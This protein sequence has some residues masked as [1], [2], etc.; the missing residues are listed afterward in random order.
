MKK[1]LL[2]ILLFLAS[3]TTGYPATQQVLVANTMKPTKQATATPVP[4]ATIDYAA[5][6]EIAQATANKAMFDNLQ[7]TLQFQKDAQEQLQ[8]TA[9]ADKRNHEILSWTATAALTSFPATATQ[10]AV[11]NTQIPAKQTEMA[12][13][14]TSTAEYPSLIIEAEDAKNYAQ[15]AGSKYPA[16]IFLLI[17]GGVCFLA[18]AWWVIT[19]AKKRAQVVDVEDEPEVKS[20]HVNVFT[21]DAHSELHTIPGTPEEFT[22]LSIAITSGLRN[23][24]INRWQR[25]GDVL[26]D[27]IKRFRAWVHETKIDGREMVTVMPKNELA[28]T[29]EFKEFCRGW[30]DT[31]TLPI[32]Y[33]FEGAGQEETEDAG[34]EESPPPSTLTPMKLS[35]E[36]GNPS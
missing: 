16:E 31:H 5:T 4:S 36:G 1:Y 3:C 34:E 13:Q 18:A 35:K 17:A 32:G 26:K 12:A 2:L 6:L 8:M 29:V 24:E 10:Q 14:R 21:D 28:P 23:F 9:D 19:D 20:F 15:W 11:I 30:L 22:E 27:G 7:V 33:M 25:E